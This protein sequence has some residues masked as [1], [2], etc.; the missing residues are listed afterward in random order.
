MNKDCVSRLFFSRDLR[1]MR[2]K[3][4]EDH[5]R[6]S[7]RM[8]LIVFFLARCAWQFPGLL[9]LLTLIYILT[10]LSV[11]E[12]IESIQRECQNLGGKKLLHSSCASL[13]LRHRPHGQLPYSFTVVNGTLSTT[14]LE[15]F[16]F[17]VF[18]NSISTNV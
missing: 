5:F 11:K 6:W 13:V 14:N 10:L 2:E 15:S 17:F 16:L 12:P 8:F 3:S 4:R 7:L 9:V 18:F 1:Q